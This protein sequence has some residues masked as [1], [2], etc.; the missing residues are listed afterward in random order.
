MDSHRVFILNTSGMQKIDH[1][2]N[3]L[4]DYLTGDLDA[5]RTA[6]VEHTFEEYPHLRQM[7]KELDS[8]EG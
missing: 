7:V 2:V 6:E 4:K 8:E 3:L 5:Q 1:I